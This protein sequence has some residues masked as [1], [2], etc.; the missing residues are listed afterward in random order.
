MIVVDTSAIA[1]IYF[2]EPDARHLA[3]ALWASSETRISAGTVL[4]LT[5]VL[6]TRKRETARLTELWLNEFLE[7][8]DIEIEPVSVQQLQVARTA[9]VRYGKGMSHPAQLNFGD[10]F[11]Y[12]LAKWLDA[13]LLF[14][15]NDFSQTDIVSAL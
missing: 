9:Y 12:A 5:I 2:Q 14:K 10:C 8:A 6:A 7:Q 11:A 13:P 1:A 4:E 15:G 3:E